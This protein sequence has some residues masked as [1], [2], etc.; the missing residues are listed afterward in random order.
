MSLT[1]IILPLCR[2]TYSLSE[3]SNVGC[4]PYLKFSWKSNPFA[5]AL[6]KN[7]MLVV[8]RLA[9]ITKSIIFSLSARISVD[10][11]FISTLEITAQI[12]MMRKLTERNTMKI[13]LNTLVIFR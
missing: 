11:E 4:L 3:E 1:E 12:P 2:Y 13:F 7:S 8:F 9:F 6:F 5:F 10:F